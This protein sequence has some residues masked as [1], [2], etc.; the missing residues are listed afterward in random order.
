MCLI[1]SRKVILQIIEEP[2]F[3]VAAHLLGVD[4]QDC[5]EIEDSREGMRAAQ[6][7]GMLAIGLGLAEWFGEADA[8]FPGL[9]GVSLNDLNENRFGQ[10]FKIWKVRF[11]THFTFQ[12]P[13]D[14]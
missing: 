2:S 14:P 11:G 4:P 10:P 12:F 9:A 3:L 1:I 6:A 13:I 5:L 7:D 8:I